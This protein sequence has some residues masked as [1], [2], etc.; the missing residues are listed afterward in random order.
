M[1]N[2]AYGYAPVNETKLYYEV[3][4]DGPALILLHAGIADSRM[5]D[6]HFERYSKQFRVVRYDLR[7]FGKSKIP[8]GS[9]S[10]YADLA[11]LMDH[12]EIERAHIL[13][14]SNGGRVALD[15]ALA[16][17]KRVNKLVL[18]TPSMG[19]HPP[20]DIIKQFWRDEEEALQRNDLEA[21]TELNLRLWVDGPT[22]APDEVNADVREKVYQMQL[23]AFKIEEPKDAEE[24]GLTPH[25]IDRLGEIK[26]ETLI[27]V[28]DLDLEEKVALS[29]KL[30]EEIQTAKLAIIS[31]AAH[32]LTMEKP[33]DFDK[34]ML[35]FLLT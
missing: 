9:Y 8:P 33:D 27:L 20:S 16:Y 26:A 31:G 6:G 34:I 25:A 32:M 21:A 17:P 2:Q 19:G 3:A 28:G 14:I 10:G 23:L 7:G 15:F 24:Q 11:G 35:E 18:A 29:K 13:G 1:N 30:I 22:R 5:W 12:L 4:G